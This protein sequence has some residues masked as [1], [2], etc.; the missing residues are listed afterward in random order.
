[1]LDERIVEVYMH[2]EQIAEGQIERISLPEAA[3]RLGVSEATLRSWIE[4]GY[5]DAYSVGAPMRASYRSTDTEPSSSL[6]F[7]DTRLP[8]FLTKEAD[9]I[10]LDAEQVEELAERLAWSYLGRQSWMRDEEE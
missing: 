10:Y 5:L 4:Q 3:A 6:M 7:L 2:R 9:S 1:M 8:I